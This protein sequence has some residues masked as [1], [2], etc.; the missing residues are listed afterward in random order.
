[1]S[2]FIKFV[3]LDNLLVTYIDECGEECQKETDIDDL[4]NYS[5]D[6]DLNSLSESDKIDFC[7]WFVSGLG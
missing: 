1:M 6:T 4:I 7:E 5:D 2:T 3:D